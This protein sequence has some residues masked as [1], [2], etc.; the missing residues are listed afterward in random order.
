MTQI[1][2]QLFRNVYFWKVKSINKARNLKK[3]LYHPTQCPNQMY[4]GI[5]WTLVAPEK[6]LVTLFCHFFVAFL[7]SQMHWISNIFEYTAKT[8][9]GFWVSLNYPILNFKKKVCLKN[10]WMQH[11]HLLDEC[12]KTKGS[13]II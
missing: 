4:F 6:V 3:V 5:V 7:L 10:V 11:C 13:W 1:L 12:K 8:T 9:G 2:T